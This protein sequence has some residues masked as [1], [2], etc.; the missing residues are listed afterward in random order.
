MFQS[1]QEGLSRNEKTTTLG[2][3]WEGGEDCGQKCSSR[4]ESEC[5]EAW[6]SI[7]NRVVGVSFVVKQSWSET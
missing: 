6:F 5:L 3:L 4:K 2:S 7:F 1:S